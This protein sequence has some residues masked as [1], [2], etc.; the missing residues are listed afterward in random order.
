MADTRRRLIEIS[1][2][3]FARDGFDQVTTEEI[4]ARAG[5]SPSTLFRYFATKESLLFVGE[6]DYTSILCQAVAR[7]PTERSDIQA[8]IA[9]MVELGPMMAAVRDRIRLYD[10]VVSSSPLLLGR[11][12]AHHLENVKLIAQALATRRSRPVDPETTLLADV[13]STVLGRA[14]AE[15]QTDPGGRELVDVILAHFATVRSAFADSA[16]APMTQLRAPRHRR[17]GGE[18]SG[19]S[20]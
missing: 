20:T 6:Y 2:E 4:A 3:L 14:H 11:E 18:P 8:L 9:S 13:G 1:L 17:S 5:V 12:R 10:Q 19:G 16:T 15:W 7:Q